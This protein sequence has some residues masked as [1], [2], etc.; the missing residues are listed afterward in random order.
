MPTIVAIVHGDCHESKVVQIV[1]NYTDLWIQVKR[2]D[3]MTVIKSHPKGKIET[4]TIKDGKKISENAAKVEAKPEELPTSS[5]NLNLSQKE[6][7]DRS[8]VEMPF[9]KKKEGKI[10]YVPDENDDWDDEDPDEDLDF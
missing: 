10:D 5:F 7:E 1:K 9:W 2:H 4:Y 3:E 8:K 6:K